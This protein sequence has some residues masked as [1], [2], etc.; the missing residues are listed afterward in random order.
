MSNPI[1]DRHL[2]VDAELMTVAEI[3]IVSLQ[4]RTG[5]ASAAP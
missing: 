3:S 5:A 1:R 4:V 2:V